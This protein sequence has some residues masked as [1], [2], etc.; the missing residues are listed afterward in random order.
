[1][2]SIL[3][4]H[5]LITTLPSFK[6]AGGIDGYELEARLLELKGRICLCKLHELNSVLQ[7]H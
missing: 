1:M 3:Y 4:V 5:V 7:T 2:I 6:E